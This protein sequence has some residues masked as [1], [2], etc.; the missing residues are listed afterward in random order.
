MQNDGNIVKNPTDV[1]CQSH[2]S[3]VTATRPNGQCPAAPERLYKQVTRVRVRRVD[4]P[5]APDGRGQCRPGLAFKKGGAVCRA[6]DVY[7]R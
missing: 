3:C 1:K 2:P 4:S 6:D 7:L 5:A